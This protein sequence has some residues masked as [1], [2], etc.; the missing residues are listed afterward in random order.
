MNEQNNPINPMEPIK[1]IVLTDS[2]EETLWDKIDRIFWST[3]DI[4][5]VVILSITLCR[6][7]IG[8]ISFIPSDSMKKTLSASDIII[9]K[10]GLMIANKRITLNDFLMSIPVFGWRF[11]E[12]TFSKDLLKKIHN[13]SIIT[14]FREGDY[15][16]YCKRVIGMPGDLIWFN[17]DD[18]MV[19]NESIMY[20]E[21]GKLFYPEESYTLH[22][23]DGKNYPMRK[24]ICRLRI[25]KGKNDFIKFER[26]HR[27]NSPI[28]HPIEFVV[29]HGQV[30]ECGDNPNFS[31]DGRYL[32]F[33]FAQ[34]SMIQGILVWVFFSSN[35]HMGLDKQMGWPR[36]ILEIAYKVFKYIINI[37][38]ARTGSVYVIDTGNKENLKGRSTKPVAMKAT[39]KKNKATKT[40]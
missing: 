33:N 9:Q 15:M 27:P 21:N 29:P 35:Y 16:Q 26:I 5:L 25:G 10:K 8:D 18:I 14:F 28:H 38:F 6:I 37:T 40:D 4:G 13:G 1:P 19:N 2:E 17:G 22:D 23:S 24:R 12:N 31:Y 7:M 32:D 30:F 11:K 34:I 20:D 3:W 36:F 39:L